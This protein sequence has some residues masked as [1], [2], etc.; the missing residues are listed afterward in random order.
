[1]NKRVKGLSRQDLVVL[2]SYHIYWI[3]PSTYLLQ[4]VFFLATR[5]CKTFIKKGTFFGGI[6]AINSLRTNETSTNLHSNF[7]ISISHVN[8]NQTLGIVILFF[9]LSHVLSCFL[10]LVPNLPKPPGS[11]ALRNYL[12]ASFEF[13]VLHLSKCMKIWKIITNCNCNRYGKYFWGSTSKK[14]ILKYQV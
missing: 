6:Q 13:D 12:M 1:M 8:E 4:K 9:L 14:I 2:Y 7:S 5:C 11:N 10:V 3:P